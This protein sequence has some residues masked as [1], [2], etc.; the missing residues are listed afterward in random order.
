MTLYRTAG[1][2]L[3]GALLAT[4][5][6]AAE[7]DL[8]LH[9]GAVYTA[10]PA[11]PWAQAVAVRD[12]AITY[13]GDD[14]GAKALAG[15]GT[16]V[17]DLSGRMVTPGFH[18]VHLHA[19]SAG[20]TLLGCS[21][22][23]IRPVE[24]LLSAI[25]GCAEKVKP[26]EWV[27]GSGFDLSLFAGGNPGKSLLDAISTDKPMFMVG[28]DG[29][30]AW[31]N[32]KALQLAGF[33]K[34]TPNPPKGVIMRDPASGEPS[35]TLRE[36]AQDPF[37]KLMPQP[38]PEQNL[39]ALR[40]ALAHLNAIGI[41]SFVDASVGEQELKAYHAADKAGALSARIVTSLTYGT[42]SK[43]PGGEFDDV[44]ARRKQYATPRIN[45]DAVKIFVDGVLEGETAALVDPYTG[46]GQ[47][48]GEL[49]LAPEELNAAV[50]RFDA[51]GIQVHMHAIGDG[52]VRAGLDA[53]E[54]ARGKN[55][56]TDNRH[57]ISH[58]QLIHPAD[59]PRFAALNVS[60]N[61]QALWAW[62]DTWIMEM[63]LPVVGPER[64]NRMYPIR[65]VQKAGGRIVAGSDWDVSSA[66]PLEEIEMALRRSDIGRTDGPVLNADERVDLDTM[67]AA[68]T[69]EAAWLMHH[70]QLVGTVAVGKRADLVVLDRNLFR[71]P[72]AEISDARVVMTFLDGQAVYEAK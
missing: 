51:M 71:I 68:F 24:A 37:W 21:L 27:Y 44:L 16:R 1:L 41:T 67:L 72:A 29:H 13:V 48:R 15:A 8:V 6:M 9:N 50:A 17:V 26:G 65:S 18:D 64:V 32:S 43:H 3:L 45:T 62:P 12:G 60:A 11:R 59:V 66:N 54:F 22:L 47:H 38:T 14:A 53:F 36:T 5:A 31:V 49:N 20:H 70:D 35:G 7:A 56:T 69:R 57:H 42:F 25:K 61:F 34:D 2:A 19:I 55:G 40:A 33:T 58:L 63:N 23:D 46:M 4:P 28:S 10:D 30:N 39:A 52:A